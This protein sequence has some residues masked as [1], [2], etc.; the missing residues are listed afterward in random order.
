MKIYLGGVFMDNK[1]KVGEIG[2]SII[3]LG[4]VV[5]SSY[6]FA[7]AQYYKGRVDAKKEMKEKLVK[8]EEQLK[9][10]VKTYENN[11]GQTLL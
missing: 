10:V 8:M 4:C 9:D 11:S 2:F 3:V 7:K 6:C 1:N 5:L